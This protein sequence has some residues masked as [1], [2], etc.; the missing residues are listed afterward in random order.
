MKDDDNHTNTYVVLAQG[1]MVLNY[2]IVKKI[3]AGGMGEV[4]LAEDTKLKRQ[5]ALKFLPAMYSADSDFRA[6]F[7]REAEATAKLNHPNIVTIYEVSEYKGQPF[8]AM[9][10]IEG[11]SLR[12][13]SKNKDLD[14][15]KIIE[16][17]I[18]ICSALSF[19]HEKKVIHRDIKPA[20]IVIDTYGRPKILDFGLAAIQGGEQL[21]KTGSTLGTIRYMSPEQVLGKEVDHRSDLF[22]LGVVLYEM[23]TARTPFERDNEAATL[24]SIDQDTPEPLRRFKSNIP[25]ELQRIIS[26]LL[27]KDPSLRYQSATGIISDLKP[28]LASTK[29]S[30]HR[31]QTKT[32]NRLSLMFGSLA[33]IVVLVVLGIIYWPG[34]KST[35]SVTT[36]QD[37]IMLAVLP[38]ENLGSS[39]DEYFADG[40]TDEIT[41]QV[42]SLGN[43]GVIA[44]TSVLQYKGTTKRISEIGTELGVDYI[45]EGTIRWDKSGT[46]NKV[47]IT[48]Q[49]IRVSD[50]THLW[51][52]NFQKDL[53]EIFEVQATIATSIVEALNVTLLTRQDESVAY[54]PTENLEA[55][56]YYLRGKDYLTQGLD[57]SKYLTAIRL[58]D[59][60]I[61][62]DSTFALAFCWKSYAH[63]YYAFYWEFG[64]SEHTRPARIAYQKAF[65]LS[66]YLAEAHLA[67][68]TYLNLID[69]DYTNALVELELAQHGQL[70]EAMILS[71]ITIIKMRQ[72]KWDEA[73]DLSQQVIKLDPRSIQSTELAVWPLWYTN[74]YDKAAKL[75]DKAL[76]LQPDESSLYWMKMMTDVNLGKSSQELEQTLSIWARNVSADEM[77]QGTGG[78]AFLGFFRFVQHSFDIETEIIRA[79]SRLDKQKNPNLYFYIG[80]LYKIIDDK[81]SS[82][83]YLD[84]TR[85]VVENRVAEIK[86]DIT[87]RFEE[88][89]LEHNVYELLAMSYSLADKHEKAI[90][91]AQMAMEVMPI[92]ACHW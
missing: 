16:M 54:H 4:Y 18:Q 36:N 71:N 35:Q 9:E 2:R 62:L 59:K 90:E 46:V 51:A 88:F 39:E 86:N 47:R 38:F 63:S 84:S 29:D 30:I 28:L 87:G 61:S 64:G 42:A 55:Y 10:L 22:S 91:Q 31:L 34:S 70:E 67:R 89:A 77:L 76:S 25:D 79:K 19:A 82:L 73:L 69:R 41:S 44:R 68:G 53:S 26:K 8:F 49:L 23:I 75:L 17:A 14:L 32:G 12:D 85:I 37:R 72:G 56:D 92:E 33:I 5:V 24:K 50:E 83:N 45:L 43:L 27:E 40:I 74:K 7:I 21:T 48:P 57:P 1:T 15:D 20:N 80:Y 58:F 65:E 78:I 60:S 6:R 11:Q 81:A 66:P 13:L 3:G 52:E